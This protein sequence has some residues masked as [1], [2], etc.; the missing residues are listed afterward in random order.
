MNSPY[1][2]IKIKSQFQSCQIR[3]HKKKKKR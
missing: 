3:L 1:G 2:N